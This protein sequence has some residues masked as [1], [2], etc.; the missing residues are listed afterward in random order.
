MQVPAVGD[1]EL[2][3]TSV[4]STGDYAKMRAWQSGRLAASAETTLAGTRLCPQGLRQDS[5]GPSLRTPAGPSFNHKTRT[6]PWA[7]SSLFPRP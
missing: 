4:T 6:G 1:A 5:G 7:W 3:L 2:D